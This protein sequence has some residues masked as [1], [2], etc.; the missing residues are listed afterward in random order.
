MKKYLNF[1]IKFTVQNE[2]FHD[3]PQFKVHHL[4]KILVPVSDK[5]LVII[6]VRIRKA[7]KK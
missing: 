4:D 1:L 7:L 2:E 5:P 3:S 6:D